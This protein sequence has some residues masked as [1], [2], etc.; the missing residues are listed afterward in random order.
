MNDD[1]RLYP[2]SPAE[3]VEGPSVAYPPVGGGLTYAR[4]PDQGRIQNFKSGREV[5]GSRGRSPPKAEAFVYKSM[6]FVALAVS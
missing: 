3:P 4:G 1:D 2:L 5:K 6:G